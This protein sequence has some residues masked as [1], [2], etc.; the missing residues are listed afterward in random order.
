MGGGSTGNTGL[1]IIQLKPLKVRKVSADQVVNRLRPKTARVP[2]IN[3]YLQAIQDVRMGGR[4]GRTQYQYT[5]QDANLS[6][7][8]HWAPLLLSKLQS[9]PEF[10]DVATDQQVAGLQATVKIDRDTAARLGIMPQAI[11][12]TLYDAFGQRQVSTVYTELNSYRG[13]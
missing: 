1:L 12:D 6:E 10:R 7:L 11:D 13:G 8:L 3:L 4:P 2:G 5:L 9:L